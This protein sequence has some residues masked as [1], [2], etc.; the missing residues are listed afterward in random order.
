MTL[1]AQQVKNAILNSINAFCGIRQ[2]ATRIHLVLMG[3]EIVIITL[4]VR[5]AFSVVMTIVQ[6]AQ[7]E[8]TAVQMMV[9]EIFKYFAAD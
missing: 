1:I 4:T 2:S 7:Q 6:V 3:K 9:T 8:W 5:E